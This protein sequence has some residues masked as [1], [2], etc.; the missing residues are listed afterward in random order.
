MIKVF[1]AC[2]EVIGVPYASAVVLA[3][4]IS[5]GRLFTPATT[6]V[7]RIMFCASQFNFNW[8]VLDVRLRN[9]N[10]MHAFPGLRFL[11]LLFDWINKNQCFKP[12]KNSIQFPRASCLTWTIGKCVRNK[13]FFWKTNSR[14]SL[15]VELDS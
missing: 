5:P 6:F 3:S 7:P 10:E 4:R 15:S 8:F 14:T 2:L 1:T 12:E 13:L 11:C 9:L